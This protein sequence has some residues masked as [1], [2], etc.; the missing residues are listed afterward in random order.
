VTLRRS[1]RG[2]ALVAGF[3]SGDGC[4]KVS[5]RESN[6]YKA[7]SRVILIF[8]LTQH[9][10]DEF[11]L[12]SMINFFG[13]GQTFNY[14]DYVEFRCQSF[15][16]NYENILPF[17]YKYPI[18]VVKAQDTPPLGGGVSSPCGSDFRD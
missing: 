2:A 14:K 6:L 5:I 8:L 9:N 4:F 16:K 10:R 17:F 15:K 1:R 13:C 3:T 11:L 7:G 12:K 18:L